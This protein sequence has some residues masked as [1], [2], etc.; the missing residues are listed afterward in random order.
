MK[1]LIVSI[2]AIALLALMAGS[3][4]AADECTCPPGLSPGFWKHNV[5]VYLGEANGSY[6]DPTDSMWVSQDTMGAWLAHLDNDVG[7][8][9]DMWQLYA[10]LCTKGGGAA[11]NMLRVDAANVFNSY[12]GLAWYPY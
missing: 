11:G 6:S 5:G 3:V 12:A 9:L 10:D 4:Y 8:E 7:Y 2:A 1:K